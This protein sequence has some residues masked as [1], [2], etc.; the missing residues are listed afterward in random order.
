MKSLYESILRKSG[1]GLPANI[2]KLEELRG[3]HHFYGKS[4]QDYDDVDITSRKWT[5]I[6]FD[7]DDSD[8]KSGVVA[9][10]CPEDNWIVYKYND[11]DEFA[12]VSPNFQRKIEIKDFKH[13]WK[14]C[15]DGATI[16]EFDEVDTDL[17]K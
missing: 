14:M 12:A 9:F 5:K 2:K 7:Q 8:F 6:E 16:P 10:F 15:A 11:S 17:D 3:Q 13:F 1:V 4:F